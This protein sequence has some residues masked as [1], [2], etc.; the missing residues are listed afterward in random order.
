MICQWAVFRPDTVVYN[1]MHFDSN[2][3]EN[4]VLYVV[5]TGKLGHVLNSAH[6]LVFRLKVVDLR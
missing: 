6:E 1:V 5:R 4:Q 3:L 2:V